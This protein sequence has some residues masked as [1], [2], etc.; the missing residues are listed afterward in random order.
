MF[1]YIFLFQSPQAVEWQVERH[2]FCGAC[3]SWTSSTDELFSERNTSATI[4]SWTVW[5]F[6]ALI[7]F[8]YF[9]SVVTIMRKQQRCLK[10]KTLIWQ[11]STFRHFVHTASVLLYT[12]FSHHNQLNG[13]LK[14]ITFAVLAVHEQVALMSSS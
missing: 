1:S 13:D 9:T 8:H 3:S 2:H 10:L 4:C 5:H 11:F 12:S 7:V 6:T 14:G